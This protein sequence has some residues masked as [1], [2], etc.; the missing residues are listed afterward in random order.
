MW[1]MVGRWPQSESTV[2]NTY[3]AML[4][5][6]TV[7]NRRPQRVETTYLLSSSSIYKISYD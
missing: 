1:F 6:M 7:A 4:E 3:C 2:W 5:M